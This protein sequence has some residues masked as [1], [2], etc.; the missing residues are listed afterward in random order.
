MLH[1]VYDPSVVH[2]ASVITSPLSFL[3]L[4][5]QLFV[6]SQM[7]GED[8]T[9]LVSN[10]TFSESAQESILS[11]TSLPPRS[12]TFRPADRLSSHFF[13]SS[14]DGEWTLAVYDMATDGMPGSISSWSLRFDV[15]PCDDEVRWQK[16]VTNACE[17][18]FVGGGEA[19]LDRCNNPGKEAGEETFSPR[20]LHTSIAVGDEVFVL[21]GLVNGRRLSDVWRYGPNR[22]VWTRVRGVVQSP[23]W[24]GQ[25]AVLTPW[26]M[27]AIGGIGGGGASRGGGRP[28][29]TLWH[30]SIPDD[31][32]DLL[33][34]SHSEDD[35]M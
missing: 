6:S 9:K 14:A 11:H 23:R 16:I 20:H 10:I 33:P 22:G 8:C 34:I 4:T 27:L 17:R 7:Q 3:P 30:Y 5:P 18:A 25:T 12:G 1:I 28:N 31:T 2:I 13:G 19:V 35:L 15:H 29:E 24:H 21:G 32:L 26:G